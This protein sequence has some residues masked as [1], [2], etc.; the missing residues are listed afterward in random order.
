MEET[1]I[2]ETYTLITNGDNRKVQNTLESLN[3]PIKSF[4]DFHNLPTRNVLA[5]DSEKIKLFTMFGAVIECLP[6]E[7]REDAKYLTKFVIAVAGGLFDGALSFLWDETVKSLRGT[8]VSYDLTY[9]Y[10]IAEQINGKYRNL[11]NEDD[12]KYILDHDLLEI[13]K[14][15]GLIDDHGYKTLENVNYLRNHASSAHPN[16]NELTGIK[17]LSLLEDCIKYVIILEP[18][19]SVL[20][21]K[22]LFHNLRKNIIPDEDFKLI[23]DSIL[24]QPQVRIDDFLTSIFGVYCGDGHEEY[25]YNNIENIS[26]LIW[27]SSSNDTKYA[28]G[29]KFGIFRK[30][31]DVTKRD[32]VNRFLENVDG[33]RYKDEDSLVAE[34]LDKL[35]LLRSAHFGMNNFYNEYSYARDI[36]QIIPRG[37]VPEPVKQMFIKIICLCYSGNGNGFRDGIDEQA[38]EIYL[39][40]INT[41]NAEDTKRFILMFQDSEFTV[42]L[43]KSKADRRMRQLC[44]ILK[45]RNSNKNI[46][47]A[48]DVIINHPE[49]KLDTLPITSEYISAVGKL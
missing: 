44:E 47:N 6:L 5:P 41:F 4:L 49:R 48:L 7:K 12:L 38:V 16:E 17:L 35:Q 20:E 2:N 31:G 1:L 3:A 42:D 10:S 25:V 37:G 27:P 45:S 15:M 11:Y 21:I 40:L 32:R 36:E 34:I 8:I 23:A 14:R 46:L 30:N 28:I 43:Y 24:E 13:S 18:N 22:K 19:H 26:K 39:K 29:S 33:L 9:F